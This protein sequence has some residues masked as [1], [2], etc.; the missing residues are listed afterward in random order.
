MTGRLNRIMTGK[1]SFVAEN[2]LCHEFLFEALKLFGFGKSFC[3]WVKILYTDVS[4][5]V[6]NGG[7][8]FCSTGYFKLCRNV[9]GD[10]LSPYLFLLAIET[11]AQVV[12]KDK[13]IKGF[14]FGKHEVRQILY[15]DDIT[16]F[17]KDKLSMDRLQHILDEFGKVS[18]L[19]VNKEKTH[20]LW[21]GRDHEKPEIP[22]FGNLVQEVKILGV[23][24][25]MNTRVKDDLNFKEILSKIKKLLGWWKGRD[26]TL[27]GKIHLLKT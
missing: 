4:S 19:I 24:F 16:L 17:V 20:L 23:Y 27:M 9:Q 21:M 25:S 3:S 13:S 12:R 15:A 26:L 10:P 11:L 2:T 6:M 5:C 8:S 22:L 7:K 18:G 14:S 1:T